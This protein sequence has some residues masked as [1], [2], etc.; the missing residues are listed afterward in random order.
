MS[1]NKSSTSVPS[2]AG[3]ST[4]QQTSPAEPPPDY[5]N[6]QASAS[7]EE[8]PLLGSSKPSAP[9]AAPALSVNSARVDSNPHST[10]MY[11]NAGPPHTGETGHPAHPAHQGHPAHPAAYSAAA[12]TVMMV[13]SRSPLL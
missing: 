8:Q 5:Y 2:K 3:G 7:T 6:S 10:P 4:N 12:V 1:D 13:D 9:Y 11:P